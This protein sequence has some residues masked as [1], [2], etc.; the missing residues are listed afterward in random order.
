[1]S[2]DEGFALTSPKG[3]PLF[4]PRSRS[5]LESQSANPTITAGLGS[6]SVSLP[7]PPIVY[8]TESDSVG[9]DSNALTSRRHKWDWDMGDPRPKIETLGF[10]GHWAGPPG[11]L[12][13]T[14][15]CTG[16]AV[17]DSGISGTAPAAT[18]ALRTSYTLTP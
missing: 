15:R 10:A 17:G 3:N 11:K 16:F 14:F 8:H 9:V 2:I 13:V 18:G 6:S 4:Y 7:L 1:M 12:R 5:N